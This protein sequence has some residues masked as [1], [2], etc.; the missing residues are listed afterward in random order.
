MRGWICGVLLFGGAAWGDELEELKRKNEELVQRVEA[1]EKKDIDR[2]IEE[3]L[4]ATAQS[5]AQ[6][7]PTLT[8][9]AMGLRISGQIRVRGEIRDNL[10][11]D[12]PNGE[13][14]FNII[15]LRTRIRFDFDVT[16]SIGATIE[17]QDVRLFGEAQST[18]GQLD[19]VDLKRGFMF[20]RNLGGQPVDIELGRMV[21]QYGDQ[22]LIGHLEWVDQGRSYDGIRILG[23]PE[24]WFL[25]GF[26]YR[27]RETGS[28]V[29][30]QNFF[31]L[32]G[33]PKWLDLYVLGLQDQMAETG[34]TG[35]DG[36]TLF[37]TFGFR[38][39]VKWGGL[40]CKVELPVQLGD[41][42]GD[43]LQ[44]WAAAVDLSYTFE[45]A[46]WQPKIYFVF[47]YASGDDNPND[48]KVKQFQTLF[49]TNHLHYGYADQVG[50][51]NIINFRLGFLLKPAKNWKIRFDYHHFRRPEAE[52]DWIDA[53][54]NV[55][56]P[57]AAGSSKH[58]ADEFDI[59]VTWTPTKPFSLEFGWALFLPGGFIE[60][61]GSSPTANFVYLQAFLQF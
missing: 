34:E 47:A 32:Y 4:D 61:T 45:N 8:P 3:Y 29:Q 43:D 5:Q 42:N 25:D 56:R 53:A 1:L 49:P 16:E 60:D 48:G 24:K 19:N 6:G 58:L 10:Y 33:G 12:Q 30:N 57:G 37:W 9:G 20:F 44:A 28:D 39:H 41:L 13:F 40:F 50:W 59:V 36:K 2:D 52:G 54:G 14:S 51:S 38:A 46:R 18:T 35:A 55:V 15:R 31:G 23:H 17:L 22:R 11:S 7:D 26:A 27:I 21:I